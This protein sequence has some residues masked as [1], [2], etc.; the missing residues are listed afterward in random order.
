MRED[1]VWVCKKCSSFQTSPWVTVLLFLHAKV[2]RF[3]ICKFK[4]QQK[5]IERSHLIYFQLPSI[6]TIRDTCVNNQTS[7]L[8]HTCTLHNYF[9]IFGLNSK[10]IENKLNGCFPL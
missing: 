6:T 3:S 10:V 8:Y 2:K 5:S 7:E 1:A 9:I 4:L